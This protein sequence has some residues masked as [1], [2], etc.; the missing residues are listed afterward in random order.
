[1]GRAPTAFQCNR[2]LPS[3]VGAAVAA[4]KEANDAALALA[5]QNVALEARRRQKA[6]SMLWRR[7]HLRV[8]K[9]GRKPWDYEPKP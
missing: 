9:G 2:A 8:V 7:K 1:L 6:A 5:Q 3:Q 4:L